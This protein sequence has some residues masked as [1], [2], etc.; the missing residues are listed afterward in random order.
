MSG[1][2]EQDWKQVTW[3]KA[4]A[5]ATRTGTTKQNHVG[6]RLHKLDNIGYDDNATMQTKT[7]TRAFSSQLQ[8]ARLSKSLTQ[9]ALAAM[10]NEKPT[11]V[12]DYEAGK[13]VPNQQVIQK[14]NRALGIQLVGNNKAK[15]KKPTKK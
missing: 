2:V 10:I 4:P 15:P 9:K 11:V 1:P 3:T 7:V 12:N 6:A 14:L 8:S 13:A 5:A